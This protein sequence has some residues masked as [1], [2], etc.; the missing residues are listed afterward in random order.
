MSTNSS[1]SDI[2]PGSPLI[3][4]ISHDRIWT[5]QS[6]EAEREQTGNVLE[7]FE[8]ENATYTDELRQSL[9]DDNGPNKIDDLNQF[10]SEQNQPEATAFNMSNNVNECMGKRVLY[11][12]DRNHLAA[13][14]AICRFLTSDHCF[15]FNGN[16]DELLLH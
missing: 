7:R 10:M 8:H 4:P 12:K 16:D 14:N 9:S 13:L 15:N 11:N 6:F 3:E 1:D 2:V 5:S